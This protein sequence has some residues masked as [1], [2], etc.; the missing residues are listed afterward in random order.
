MCSCIGGRD[1]AM[2]E[3]DILVIVLTG[4]EAVVSTAGA[5]VLS[6]TETLVTFLS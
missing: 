2:E 1:A 5:A 3:V 4:S 6:D